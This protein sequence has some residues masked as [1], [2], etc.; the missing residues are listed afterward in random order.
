MTK[1]SD[2]R[3]GGYQ[4][5]INLEPQPP[6]DIKLIAS[7][8]IDLLELAELA[9]L[10]F[11]LQWRNNLS[12]CSG[13]STHTGDGHWPLTVFRDVCP[14]CETPL[15]EVIRR[16]PEVEMHIHET[17]PIS[18]ARHA[19]LIQ[20]LKSKP[21]TVVGYR[22]WGK[23]NVHYGYQETQYG[24]QDT[25]NGYQ[26]TQRG[27]QPPTMSKAESCEPAPYA[28]WRKGQLV[29]NVPA[30]VMEEAAAGCS[31]LAQALW[32]PEQ[33]KVEEN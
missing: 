30:P 11:E 29:A 7:S 1:M 20:E 19:E 15:Q 17:G 25:N 9:D 14:L 8:K 5:E 24:Y 23:P 21:A 4:Y 16:G 28:V 3:D 12:L 10:R 26:N 27:A 6:L 31:A 2:E 13:F 33:M 18:E 32:G 22:Y